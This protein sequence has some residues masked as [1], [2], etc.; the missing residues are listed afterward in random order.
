M[1]KHK[2]AIRTIRA[3]IKTLQQEKPKLRAEIH[4]LKFGPGGERRPET[5]PQRYGLRQAYVEQVRPSI[6]ANLLAYGLLRG[7][8]YTKMEPKRCGGE[9]FYMPG[10]V[11]RALHAAI[12]DDAA[13]KAEWTVERVSSLILDGVDPLAP[14]EAA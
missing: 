14:Q 12:G 4:A 10:R 8:P 9:L 1:K 3:T 2:D 7:V 11:L 6:R 5:G 13:L